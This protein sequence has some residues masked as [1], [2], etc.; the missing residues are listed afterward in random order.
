MNSMDKIISEMKRIPQFK[1]GSWYHSLE[2]RK[3]EEISLHNEIRDPLKHRESLNEAGNKK[4]YSVASS[5]TSYIKF[6]LE[7]EVKGKIFLDFACGNGDA[8]I[9]CAEQGALFSIGLDIS[10]VSVRNAVKAANVLPNDISS[11]LLFFQ[12]DCE[13]TMLPS[14]SIDIVLCSGMLHHLNLENAYKELARILVSGG[15]LVGIEALGHNAVFQLYRDL[16]PHLRTKWE[17][18]HI[19]QIKDIEKAVDFGFKISEL[20]FWH[21]FD[22]LAVPFRK[23]KCFK[24][25]RTLGL[26]ADAILFRLPFCKKLAW[27]VSFVLRKKHA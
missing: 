21:F 5:S 4:F 25:L 6:L 7:K 1:P 18:T 12:G 3:R 14:A 10:D 22:L 2:E 24:P 27:Q 11:K 8:A 9:W 20:R 19:M 16:T 15:L 17:S 26:F 23:T 13:N